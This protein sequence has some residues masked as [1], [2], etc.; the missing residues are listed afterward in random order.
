MCCAC[1]VNDKRFVG[2]TGTEEEEEE[3]PGTNVGG[4][5]AV[6]K[7]DSKRGPAHLA[8]EKSSDRDGRSPAMPQQPCT[9]QTQPMICN[10]AGL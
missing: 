6:L 1:D 3:K 10:N 8:W 9:R 5:Q 2:M 7:T 4:N